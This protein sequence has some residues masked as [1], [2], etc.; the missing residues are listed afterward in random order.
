MVNLGNHFFKILSKYQMC[1]F[2]NIE[3]KNDITQYIHTK[4][5]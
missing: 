2:L 3:I 1:Y 4:Q 5:S